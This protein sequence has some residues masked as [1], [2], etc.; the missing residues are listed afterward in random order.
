MS[1]GRDERA[2]FRRL[3]ERMRETN[4]PEKGDTATFWDE[5]GTLL[6][7]GIISEWPMMISVDAEWGK[8][9]EM[10]ATKPPFAGKT[11]RFYSPFP[12]VN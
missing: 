12:Q 9:Q 4:G 5:K 8:V 7:A 2:R 10:D 6:Y 11:V 3:L 1:M